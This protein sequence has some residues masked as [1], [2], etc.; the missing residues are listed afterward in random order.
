VLPRLVVVRRRRVARFRRHT[1]P[2]A[3]RLAARLLRHSPGTTTRYPCL[4]TH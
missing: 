4:L 1:L 2:A 3:C